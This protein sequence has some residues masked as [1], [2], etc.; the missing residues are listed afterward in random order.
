VQE[1]APP[2]HLLDRWGL[3]AVAWSHAEQLIGEPVETSDIEDLATA[4][5]HAYEAG[6]RAV[7]REHGWARLERDDES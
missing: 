7:A 1:H 2:P 3:A 6:Y 5:A 4:Y